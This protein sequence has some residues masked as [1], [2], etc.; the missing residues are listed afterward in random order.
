[1]LSEPV[2]VG[3]RRMSVKDRQPARGLLDHAH[4]LL[5][6]VEPH[7]VAWIAV[8]GLEVEREQRLG[9]RPRHGEESG[10][11]P[12]AWILT[13]AEMIAA[14]QQA[15]GLRLHT[16]LRIGRVDPVAAF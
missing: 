6:L 4:E 12:G 9:T 10:R 2:T 3:P 7:G 11:L 1:M 14:P 8:V 15:R 13:G 16:P 5:G